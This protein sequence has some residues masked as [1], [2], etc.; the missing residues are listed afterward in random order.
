MD[1]IEEVEAKR[2]WRCLL[3]AGGDDITPW[4][5]RGAESLAQHKVGRSSGSREHG[6]QD[7][8]EVA[9]AAGHDHQ[10][11]DGVV[12]RDALAGIENNTQGVHACAQAD[13]E[14]SGGRNVQVHLAR[15]NDTKP[16]HGEIQRGGENGKSIGK[17]KFE[18]DARNGDA[19]HNAEKRPTPT[20]AK[21]H[22]QKWCVGAGDE[23]VDGAMI[24]NHQ[25]VLYAR[26]RGAVIESGGGV[27]TDQRNSIDCA[28]DDLPAPTVEN[29]EDGQNG[30]SQQAANQAETMSQGIRQLFNGDLSR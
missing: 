22:K 18:K 16:T 4:R 25:S 8:N 3:W 13:P 21:I 30:K 19:P 17:P 7:G 24:E 9:C 5:E 20:A 2:I 28:T 10:V 26:G 6:I 11:P 29:G 23:Q 27:K 12:V 15:G 1:C 14:D